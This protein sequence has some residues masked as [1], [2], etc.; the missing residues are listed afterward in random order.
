[1][2]PRLRAYV[3]ERLGN[4]Q[5]GRRRLNE[6]EGLYR[7]ALAER[8]RA[9]GPDHPHNALTLWGIAQVQEGFAREAGTDT[10]LSV[11]RLL[12][13]AETWREALTILMTAYGAEHPRVADT[14]RN[15]GRVLERLRRYEEASAEFEEA[16][17]VYALVYPPNHPSIG[18]GYLGLA[19]S[20]L[21]RGRSAASEKAAREA[22]SVYTAHQTDDDVPDWVM[23]RL[24][25]AQRWLGQALLDQRQ[26]LEAEG[27]LRFA[28]HDYE[29]RPSRH[30]DISAIANALADL[31]NETARPD[32]AR[33]YRD[34]AP[35]VEN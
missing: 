31:F 3:L 7:E 15:L 21:L 14:H 30:G 29:S 4:I 23:E 24:A 25:I 12:D 10:M 17:R 19:R 11:T 9:L 33:R 27:A 22:I 18:D 13:A 35:R 2:S 32:S 6:A 16:I 34:Y 20:E 26:F 8:T 5:L 1:M 28:L